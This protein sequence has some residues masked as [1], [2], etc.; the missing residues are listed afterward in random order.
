MRLRLNDFKM[1]E[2]HFEVRSHKAPCQFIREYPFATDGEQETEL[3]LAVKQY[4]PLSNPRPKD[5]DI[6]IIAAHA[7][8]FGKVS[9]LSDVDPAF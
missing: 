5:G 4:I 3:Q 8:G 2:R 9:E 1:V 6:T 7:I